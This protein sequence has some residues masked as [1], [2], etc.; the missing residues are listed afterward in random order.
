MILAA[1]A[2]WVVE[3]REIILP[4]TTGGALLPYERQLISPSLVS[5]VDLFL[6][7]YVAYLNIGRSTGST[8]SETFRNF[9]SKIH[10]DVYGCAA[11]PFLSFFL[12][13]FSS[14]Y[15]IRFFIYF[16]ISY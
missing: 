12:S 3:S 1:A 11:F 4:E 5:Q 9:R 8:A 7:L 16:L 14:F 10:R 2:C 13:F 15:F 6:G